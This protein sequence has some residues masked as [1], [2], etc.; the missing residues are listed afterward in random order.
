MSFMSLNDQI[1]FFCQVIAESRNSRGPATSGGS[2][3]LLPLAW[4]RHWPRGVPAQGRLEGWL[5]LE[6][7]DSDCPALDT[8]QPTA[9][10]NEPMKWVYD[11]SVKTFYERVVSSRQ[12]EKWRKMLGGTAEQDNTAGERCQSKRDMKEH[13]RNTKGRKEPEQL[14]HSNRSRAACIGAKRRHRRR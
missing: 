10:Q 1:T 11:T 4:G 3:L 2:A 7:E 13:K 12:K 8:Q 14:R 5:A 6:K 9:T